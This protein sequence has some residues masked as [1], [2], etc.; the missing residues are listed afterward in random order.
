MSNQ[1]IEKQ[2][3]E[4][5]SRN[6]IRDGEFTAGLKDFRFSVGQGYGL[7][8]NQSYFRLELQLLCNGKPA[9]TETE[10]PAAITF[11][12][13]VCGNLFKNIMF[14]MG[15]QTVSSLT[16]SPGQCE[17][18][19]SRLRSSKTY[20]ESVGCVKGFTAHRVDRVHDMYTY[21]TAVDNKTLIK[22][23]ESTL[24]SR[25][26]STK[27]FIWQPALGIFDVAD[28]LGAG[29]YSISL[30]PD[31]DYQIAAV[32]TGLG[33]EYALP[34][35]ATAG[36]GKFSVKVVNMRF[37]ACLVRANLP[38]SGTETLYL[39]EMSVQNVNVKTS[40]ATSGANVNEEFNFPSSTHALSMFLQGTTAG[41]TTALPPSK[42]H[43]AGH[44]DN[45][46]SLM[47]YQIQYGNLTKPTIAYESTYSATSNTLQ[48]RY[49]NT[50]LESGQFFSEAGGE[51]FNQWLE[52][53]PLIHETF[54]KAADN[55]ATRAQIQA[56][57][58]KLSEDARLY[59]IA[60]YTTTV[61]IT[62]TN[63]M[64][65]NVVLVAT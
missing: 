61:Q 13:G 40:G 64:V 2:W 8:P 32:D 6:P 35:D 41:K 21:D 31:Q 42:F 55:L 56:N 30:N 57:Y 53:G 1:Y 23:D 11:A 4:I 27:M 59:V 39:E 46:V 58:A 43:I 33:T 20:D 14:Q 52:R 51:T 10:N 3:R 49:I 9:A 16:N 5:T 12:D 45:A 63:G 62:R 48:Q 65:S 24:Y 28:P 34:P 38:S 25:G 26:R 7:I 44:P 50:M 36:A 22:S 47:N 18:V 19:K 54:V 15:G 29:E 60:H 37:Y 17:I